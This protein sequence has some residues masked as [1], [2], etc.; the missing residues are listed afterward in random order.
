LL[1]CRA[2]NDRGR[3]IDLAYLAGV[4]LSRGELTEDLGK[5]VYVVIRDETDDDVWA[6][7]F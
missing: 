6:T 5:T 3:D 1:L 4:V 7:L 2:D